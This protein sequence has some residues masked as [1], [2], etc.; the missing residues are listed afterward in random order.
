MFVAEKS[1][2]IK[3]FDSLCRHDADRRSPTC[4]EGPQLLGPRPPRPGARPA[5]SPPRPT[6]TCSTPSTPPSG[7]PAAAIPTWGDSLPHPARRHHRR[8]RRQR[9]ALAPRPPRATRWRRREQVAASSDWCQQFPSHS[10]GTLD[11][12]R[13][14]RAL[15]ERR[16]RR[17]LQH[18]RTTASSAARS[19]RHA[20]APEPVRRP[21]GRRRRRQ[22]PPTAEGGALRS[23]D[24]R[25][26]PA[27]RASWTARS[28]GVDPRHRRRPCRTTRSSASSR[29]ER[30]SA[31]SRYGLRNPFRIT[32][33]PGH[34]RGLDRRRRLERLG[35]DQPRRRTR[36]PR[37]ATSAG[38]ATRARRSSRLR[39]R[40]T[41]TLCETPLRRRRRDRRARSAPTA[42][43]RG[44][45][46]RRL[47][48]RQLLGRRP[49]LLRGRQQLSRRAT[50][51]RSSSPTTRAP[52][53]G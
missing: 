48:D 50:T 14:R 18:R 30:A 9:P 7:G 34:E 31:S 20:D 46:R 43:A 22:T 32:V 28:C 29:R 37:R 3:I 1:G 51:A 8:L 42:T 2:L 12:R 47:P 45:G 33:R 41:S 53:S 5:T 11:V 24:L 26:R 44:R 13:R 6:S 52:A 35:G 39:R 38:P 19:S 36:R 25:A 27:S 15:R 21:A 10:I 40:R 49:G 17:E 23:Q 16:R 4:A